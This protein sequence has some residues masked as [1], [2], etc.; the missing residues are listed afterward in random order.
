M[1]N[2]KSCPSSFLVEGGPAESGGETGDKMGDGEETEEA[3]DEPLALCRLCPPSSD[4][5]NSVNREDLPPPFT[6]SSPYSSSSPSTVPPSKSATAA[7]ADSGTTT[8][9]SF[10]SP[11]PNELSLID[12]CTARGGLKLRSKP[13]ARMTPFRALDDEEGLLEEA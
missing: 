6:I 1:L 5:F 4:V 8:N 9:S 3:N 10:P 7:G 11:T 13:N 2:G 12:L